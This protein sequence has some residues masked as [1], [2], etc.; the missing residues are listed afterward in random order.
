MV[1]AVLYHLGR[2]V[3]ATTSIN[4]RNYKYVCFI[5]NFHTIFE[6]LLR[7]RGTLPL[8]TIMEQKFFEEFFPNLG[9][10]SH[11]HGAKFL[12]IFYVCHFIVLSAL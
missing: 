9:G 3:Q 10:K 8:T 11:F 7:Q 4:H 5:S 1:P 12:F 2:K 6:M